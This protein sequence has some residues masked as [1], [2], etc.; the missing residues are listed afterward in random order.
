VL[1]DGSTAMINAYLQTQMAYGTWMRPLQY[2]TRL[3]P[4]GVELDPVSIDLALLDTANTS[5]TPDQSK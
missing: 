3:T 5:V 2:D 1:T 4:L